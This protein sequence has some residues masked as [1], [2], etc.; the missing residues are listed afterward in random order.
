MQGKRNIF[1]RVFDATV[2]ALKRVWGWLKRAFTGSKL[3]QYDEEQIQSP[4]ALVRQAFFSKKAAVI[5][6][7]VLAALFLFVF[8]APIF[9]PMDVNYTDALQQ[10]LA[11][12]YSLRSVPRALRDDVAELDGFAGFSVG[13]NSKGEVFVWGATKDKLSKTDLQHVPSEVEQDGAA[14]VAA[15]KDHILALTTQGKIVG[16]GDN[17]CGQYGTQPTL[18]AL[19]MPTELASVQNM[20]PTMRDSG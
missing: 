2:S 13:R 19:A 5:A 10:N 18:N 14:F 7:V 9:V 17:S 11:P 1:Q 4:S 20:L 6:L 12:T 15:G 3:P 16:W 8:I